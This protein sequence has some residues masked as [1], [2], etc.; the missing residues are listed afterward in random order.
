MKAEDK[1]F[2]TAGPSAP[3]ETIRIRKLLPSR[4][5]RH[6]GGY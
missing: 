3:V 6:R 4:N 1:V 5:A 2:R